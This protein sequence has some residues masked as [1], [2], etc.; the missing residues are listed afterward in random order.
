MSN[1]LNEILPTP[2]NEIIVNRFEQQAIQAS[3]NGQCVSGTCRAAV[4][5]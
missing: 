1:I 5:Q 3:C 2:S 4:S